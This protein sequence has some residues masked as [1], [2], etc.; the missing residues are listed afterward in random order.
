MSQV[1][2]SRPNHGGAEN[3][4]AAVVSI[5]SQ[6]PSILPHDEGAPDRTEANLTYCHVVLVELVPSSANFNDVW[7]GKNDGHRDLVLECHG[8]IS[9]RIVAGNEALVRRVW[10]GGSSASLVVENLST[11]A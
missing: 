6:Q 5:D 9:H 11:E 7:I 10:K 4:A 8:P 3:A 2:G 1:L